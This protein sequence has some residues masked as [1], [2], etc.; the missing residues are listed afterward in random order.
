MPERRETLIMSQQERDRLKILDRVKEG[1]LTRSM[2]AKTLGMSERQLY[3]IYRRYTQQGDR[4]VIHRQRGRAGSNRSYTITVKKHAL[5]LFTEQYSD[6][7]PTLLSEVLLSEHGLD[8]SRQTL[9]RWLKADELLGDIRKARPHRRKRER[10]DAIGDLI[11]FDGSHH[12]W[13]EGRAEP[14]CLLV[15]ID[16]A[17][18]R[19]F[20]RFAPT[21][22]AKDVLAML[23]AYVR[24]FGVPRQFYTD[25]GSVYHVSPSSD[26]RMR[27]PHD[28]RVRL[29][30]MGRVLQR[31]GIEH[32]LA[33]SPQ[34]KGRVE[35]SNRTHQDRLIKALRRKHISSID[36]ANRFLEEYY[37]DEHN[38]RFANSAGLQDIHRSSHGLDFRNIFCFETSRCVYADY[39]IVLEGQFVQ[40][41]RSAS[42]ALPPPRQYVVVRRWLDG[43]LHIFWHDQEL[44][45]SYFSKRPK[46]KLHH[47][48][49]PSAYHPWRSHRIGRG[50]Y[51]EGEQGRQQIIASK[52]K[53]V[54][55]HP[56]PT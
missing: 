3:R 23:E 54:S 55:S 41:E 6:Y 35:R 11:Q 45:F 24:R 4:G 40:L 16:D 46:P 12:D 17:S 21:E 37:I 5:R 2:A 44:K 32:L 19:V 43:S 50:R 39:T 31:L 15:A 52:K 8:V 51:T 1:K 53:T 56:Q 49:P 36:Q 33:R 13:F 47:T 9:T 30:E 38:K 34:A 14:C 10:R 42:T 7:H 29:T 28:E 18:G 25:Y 26:R 27:G 20:L 22:N 48:P